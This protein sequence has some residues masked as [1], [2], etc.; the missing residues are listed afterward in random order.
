[1]GVELLDGPLDDPV[2]LSDNLRD[3]RRANRWLGGV[4]LSCRAV[5]ALLHHAEGA[6][7]IDVGTG[8][9]DIPLALLS[10]A[11]QRGRSWTVTALDSRPE[12][13]AAAT[14]TLPLLRSTPELVLGIGDGRALP[15][16]DTCFDIGHASLVI[17]HLE[18]PDAIGFLREL[19]RVS[20]LGIVV[21][22]LLR[23]R[24]TLAGAW[25]LSRTFTANRYTRNDAPLS[26][27]RAYTRPELHELLD[28]AGLRVVDEFGGVAGHRHALAAVRA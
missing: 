26:V 19:A 21:N 16:A 6:H 1:M 10:Y 8:G 11:R 14:A 20:R 2:M 24:L 27:R 3:L 28:A 7:I 12:V 5:E 4:Q 23:S 9:A 13:I 17:H 18:P 25:L 22:D 15:Y